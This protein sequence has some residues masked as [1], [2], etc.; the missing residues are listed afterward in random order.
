MYKLPMLILAAQ[1][2]L[3]YAPHSPAAA[4]ARLLSVG[5]ARRRSPRD[6]LAF[7]IA[8]QCRTR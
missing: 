2:T 8:M 3:A 6:V 7:P 1:L 4:V 5:M